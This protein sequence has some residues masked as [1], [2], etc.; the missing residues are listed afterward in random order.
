MI[1][2]FKTSFKENEKRVP[3]YPEH[4]S[5]IKKD[6]LKQCYF[7]KGYGLDY[8]YNDSYIE[9][10][11]AGVVERDELFNKC[12]ILILPKPVISD[13][14]KMK[15][16]QALWGWAHCVQQIEVAQIAIERK[17]TIMAWEAMH[18]WMK[19]GIG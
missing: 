1:G 2:I 6:L 3:I 12:D 10:Y 15:E 8:G 16:G 4:L 14:K 17:L 19:T 13:L 18:H 9:S 7:E 5:W 11:S